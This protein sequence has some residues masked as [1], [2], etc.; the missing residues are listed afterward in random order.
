MKKM[1]NLQLAELLIDN[2]IGQ[3]VND[4]YLF[5][6]YIFPGSGMTAGL[7]VRDWRVAGDVITKLRERGF[8]WLLASLPD[9]KALMTVTRPIS[10]AAEYVAPAKC[11][12]WSAQVADNEDALA[13]VMAGAIA[14]SESDHDS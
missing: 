3:R 6:S 9:G 7:F 1:T 13:I 8:S 2:G 12:S 11:R 4:R 14:L 10:S 5:P